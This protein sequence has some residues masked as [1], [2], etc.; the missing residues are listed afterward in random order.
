MGSF[1]EG[2]EAL[3]DGSG[4]LDSAGM[5]AES[6]LFVF[7][8]EGEILDSHDLEQSVFGEGV[9]I[10][11]D[12]AYQLTYKVNNRFEEPTRD[13]WQDMSLYIMFSD[14]QCADVVSEVQL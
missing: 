14:P 13:G 6:R 9:T 10:S 4:W 12:E 11:G 1:T 5:Y 7:T 3:P 8:E 2:L